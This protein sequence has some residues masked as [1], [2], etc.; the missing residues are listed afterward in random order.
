M[1]PIVIP[2]SSTHHRCVTMDESIHFFFSFL[3]Q[4]IKTGTL[5]SKLKFSNQPTAPVG[6]VC[7]LYCCQVG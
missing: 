1:T 3:P 5:L 7:I 6:Q 4:P 2:V